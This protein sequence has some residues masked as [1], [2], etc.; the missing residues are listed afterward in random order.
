M[1][2]RG[3]TTTAIHESGPGKE[4]QGALRFPVYDT[5]AFGFESAESMADSFSGRRQAHAY[6]RISNPTVD[7]L[8]R[9]ITA[10]E[11]A[12]ATVAVASGMAALSVTFLN[13]LKAGENIVASASLFGGT[14]T[15][16]KKILAPLGIETRFVPIDDPGAVE[17]AVDEHTRA[18]FAE[19]ISNPGMIVADFNGIASIAA[20]RGI[21]VIA[22][23]T[24]TTPYL[25]HARDYGVNVV[26]HSTTKY[27]SGGAT[28]MGGAIVD[29]G[30]FDWTKIPA[31]A[32]YHRFNEMAFIARLRRE[33]YRETGSCLAPHHAYLQTLGLET[34]ALRMER[35]CLN[36]GRLAEFLSAHS[37]VTSVRYPGLSSSPYH[38]LANKQFQGFGGI[39]SMNLKSRAEC[40]R[41]LN[42]LSVISRAS[43]LGDNKTLALHPASTIFAGFTEEELKH[44]G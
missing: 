13:L 7:A 16:F 18:V 12:K 21:P 30:N 33:V 25:F 22:D 28:T 1:K 29:L 26:L 41:F 9:R 27:V 23:S 39:L 6:T 11:S 10:L 43:N 3:F 19:T 42:R 14:Y 37:A 8:E 38:V 40:F 20:K 24:V 34:L 31:L 17:T 36:A 44:L 35:I 32:G 15:F 5:A 4:A 2:R